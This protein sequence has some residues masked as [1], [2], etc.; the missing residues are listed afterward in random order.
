MYE[1]RV[2]QYCLVQKSSDCASW[3]DSFDIVL[4]QVEI[5]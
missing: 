3:D 1:H 5:W 2:L 4:L